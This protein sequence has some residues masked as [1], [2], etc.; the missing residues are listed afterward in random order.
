LESLTQI[1]LA[2]PDRGTVKRVGVL[3]GGERLDVGRAPGSGTYS[4]CKGG[5]SELCRKKV[6]S[7]GI[8]IQVMGR[9]ILR[10]LENTDL[11]FR[12]NELHEHRLPPTLPKM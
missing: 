3:G 5:T 4:R 7:L 11:V 10:N 8:I 12:S 9:Y 1:L 2:V 6:P